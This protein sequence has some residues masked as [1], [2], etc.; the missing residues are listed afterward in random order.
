MDAE[1]PTQAG[2]PTQTEEP[3]QTVALERGALGLISAVGLASGVLSVLGLSQMNLFYSTGLLFGALIA[4]YFVV[5]E[6]ERE[7]LKLALFVTVCLGSLYAAVHVGL[8]AMEI[9]RALD[10]SHAERANVA[11][12]VAG[13]VGAFIVL[14]AALSLFGAKGPSLRALRYALVGSLGGALLGLI[15]A[16]W[17]QAVTPQPAGYLGGVDGI[18]GAL[19]VWQPGV[20]LLLGLMLQYERR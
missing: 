7:I 3:A 1:E 4:G 11:F 14:L 6:G 8:L 16:L 2:K 12:G 19:L 18:R 5:H 9:A 20:A 10:S 13:A 17:E 15:G